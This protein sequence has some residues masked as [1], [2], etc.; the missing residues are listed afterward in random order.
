MPSV[1]AHIAAN[2][3]RTWFLIGSFVIVLIVIGAAYNYLLGG[4]YGIAIALGAALFYTLLS[5]YAGD[6]ITLMVN[7]AHLVRRK[8]FPELHRVVEN[9]AI[10]AGI[11]KPKIYLIP[12]A[13]LNA[14]ATGRDAQHASVAVTVGL[15]EKLNRTELEGVIAHEL[16]HIKNYD[17]RLMMITAVLVGAIALFTD[18]ALRS[19]WWGGGRRREEG[20]N[21][22][23]AVIAIIAMI[24]APITAQLIQ[25]AVSRR[26]EYL[27]DASA[28]MLTR[29]PE[30]LAKALEKISSAPVLP[31]ASQATAHL[32]IANP[33]KGGL[34]HFFSTH[35]PIKERIK[36]LREMM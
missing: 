34:S 21:A 27:A 19:L 26:R 25:L 30:G 7:N 35:P 12:S 22:L 18:F 24:L 31:R 13:A 10:T 6:K 29:Y 20:A 11:P 15:L 1:Y 3:R 28:A 17:V 32:F 5:Y 4:R 8:Q 36:R 23:L 9:L 14:F 16:S 33:L 2:K